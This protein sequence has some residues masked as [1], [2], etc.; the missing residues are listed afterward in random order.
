[1]GELAGL[2]E[3]R[4]DIAETGNHAANELVVTELEDADFH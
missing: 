2:Q 3:F 4:L 1:M